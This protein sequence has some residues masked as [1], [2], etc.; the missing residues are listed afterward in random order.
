MKTDIPMNGSMVKN[1]ISLK[2]GFGYLAIRR[3]S[4]LSWFQACQRVRLLVLISQL[5]GH[6]SRQESHYSTSSSSLSSSPTVTSSD[7][8][9]RERE[10]QSEIDP[11]QCLCQLTLTTDRGNPLFADSGPQVLKSRSGCKNSKKIWWM[12]K[13]I[14]TETHTPVLLMKYL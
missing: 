11:L 12:M 7:S 9:S 6:L 4:F 10:D 1:H 2:T 8:E 3:T 14:N 13:F 5:Q